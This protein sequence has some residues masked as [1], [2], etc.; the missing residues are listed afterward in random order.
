[1]AENLPEREPV[2]LAPAF[3]RTVRHV[4]AVRSGKIEI[5]FER[6]AWSRTAWVA[7]DGGASVEPM[8]LPCYGASATK[9][10]A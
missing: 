1:M 9:F 6:G 5:G 2:G 10:A 4:A 7:I 3:I 8:S